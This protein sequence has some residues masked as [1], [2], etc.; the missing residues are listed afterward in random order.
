MPYIPQE[1][2]D[3]LDPI[4]DELH[5]ALVGLEADDESNNMEGNMNYLITRLLRKVYGTSYS[6]IN[7]GI[8][9]LQC[10][11]L[12]H[13]RTVAGPYE[14]QKMFDNGPIEVN[15]QKIYTTE[16]VIEDKSIHEN[17]D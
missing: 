7:A 5:R 1:K 2:R 3:V 13:Y 8:G 6:E 17:E 14:D 15:L 11:M 12:E 16:M 9:M 4:I 10:V